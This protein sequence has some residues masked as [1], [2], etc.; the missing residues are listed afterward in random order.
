MWHAIF[1][2]GSELKEFDKFGKEVL[3]SK[4]MT[5]VQD[6]KTLSII[7]SSSKIF[8]VHLQDTQFTVTIDGKKNY[9]YGFD[10]QKYNITK[11]TNIRPIYFVRET[12]K[13]QVNN[14][15]GTGSSPH[16]NFVALGFQANYDKNKN[17]KRYLAIY[18]DGK[19]SINNE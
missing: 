12:V 14:S 13:L 10:V 2:D 15:S 4:V 6:L 18:P 5:R 7:L 3:F 1:K 9:F 16:V 8:T 19:Y 11:L 17:V